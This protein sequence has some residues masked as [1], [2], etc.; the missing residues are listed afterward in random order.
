MLPPLVLQQNSLN[1]WVGGS[2]WPFRN[3]FEFLLSNFLLFKLLL[4]AC[5]VREGGHFT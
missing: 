4:S 2:L 1:L 5:S 3:T